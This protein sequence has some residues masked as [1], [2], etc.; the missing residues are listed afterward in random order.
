MLAIF[1]TIAYN[2]SRKRRAGG[3]FP[4]SARLAAKKRE[5]ATGYEGRKEK[6]PRVRKGCRNH[7]KTGG[8]DRG[9]RGRCRGGAVGRGVLPDVPHPAGE[10]RGPPAHHHRADHP[11]DGSLDEQDT[12]HAGDPAGYH[13]ICGHGRSGDDPVHPAYRRPEPGLPGGAVCGPDRRLPLPRVLRPRTG[14]PG[15]G[16]ELVSGWHPVRRLYLGRRVF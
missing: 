2:K 9:K 8:G 1:H 4:G 16:E 13:R 7:R 6:G 12:D 15:F 14:L 11:G 3:L 5:E 10:E